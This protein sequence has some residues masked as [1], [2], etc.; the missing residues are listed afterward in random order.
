M[1]RT[2][3]AISPRSS[4]ITMIPGFT[5]QS[6]R[7]ER[8]LTRRVEVGEEHP[9]ALFAQRRVFDHGVELVVHGDAARVEV[10]RPHAHPAPVD[11]TPLRVHHLAV[12]LPDP[13]P[14]REQ[15]A[16]VAAREQ[17]DPR[18]LLAPLDKNRES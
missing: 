18:L 16:V 17:P 7:L 2:R 12:P 9:L 14:V 6:Y 13:H 11:D 15:T 5:P 10:G 3:D 4:D 1:S 8:D